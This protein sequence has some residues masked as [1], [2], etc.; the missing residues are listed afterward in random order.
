MHADGRILTRPF[1]AGFVLTFLMYFAVGACIPLLPRLVTTGLGGN[2]ADVGILAAVFSLSAVLC[3]PFLSLVSRHGARALAIV[4]S[5]LAIV[6]FGLMWRVPN[7]GILALA[8]VAAAVGEALV[9]TTFSLL[10][11]S[12]A[13]EH[14]QAE[15]I[16]L[17]SVSIFL[18][19]GL[20][21]LTT[22]ALSRSGRFASAALVPTAA[23][24]LCAVCAL[25][26]RREWVPPMVDTTGRLRRTELYH[27]AALL[28]GLVLALVILGWSVWNNYVALRADEIGM[29]NAA[30]LFSVYSALSL[31]IRLVGAKLPDRIGLRR[32]ASMAAV[33][34]M[35]SLLILGWAKTS[36]GLLVGSIVMALGIAFTFP[37]LSVLALQR[38][39][40]PSQRASL[41]SSFGMFFEVG[42]GLGGLVIAP[43]ARQAG[44]PAAF[45]VAALG[46]A[47]GLAL[48]H[49]C[50]HRFAR[51]RPVHTALQQSVSTP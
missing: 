23:S 3:R 14:R 12:F 40:E 9:W 4:G 49:F 35:M 16:S 47:L 27:P 30:I 24:V 48:L 46:P 33:L 6:G 2:R 13:P 21:P 42:A 20:G 19:L 5:L 1:V 37:S 17:A 32:S 36:T 51:G 26:I 11:T 39:D 31:I 41:M 22:E 34:V 28:P 8:R 43:V 38:L 7:L 50:R 29:A 44:L 10:S 25:C 18:G 15:A 45:R